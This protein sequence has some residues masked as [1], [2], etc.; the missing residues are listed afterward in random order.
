M[1]AWRYFGTTGALL[2]WGGLFAVVLATVAGIL[3]MHVIGGAPAAHASPTET[4]AANS[5]AAH[6]MAAADH[7]TPKSQVVAGAMMGA[8]EPAGHHQLGSCSTTGDDGALSMHG[9][10]VPTFG[11][12]G[13]SV[14]PPKT[15]LLL[16][17][18]TVL[19]D[20]LGVAFT[21]RVA[22]G[23]SLTQLSISRT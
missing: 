9:G 8:V 12:S 18:G 19:G 22:D 7:G 15:F 17:P 5:V 10:C 20:T 11:S 6:P 13:I 21:D 3:G 2:R 4:V 1:P 16:P 23:P 14:S